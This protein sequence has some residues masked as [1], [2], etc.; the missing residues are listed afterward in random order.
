MGTPLFF[1]NHESIMNLAD[2]ARD[3]YLEPFERLPGYTFAT[4]EDTDAQAYFSVETLRIDG[5]LKSCI[6]L[7]FRG[8]ES[9]KDALI[10][11]SATRVPLNG[12]S[13]SFFGS[14]LPGGGDVLVHWGFYHQYR[15]ILPDIKE[16]LRVHSDIEHIVTTGHSLGGALATLAVVDLYD[17][18]VGHGRKFSCVSFGSPRVGNKSFANKFRRITGNRSLRFVNNDDPIPLLPS[19]LRFHHVHGVVEIETDS[20]PGYTHT[21]IPSRR[22]R[23]QRLSRVLMNTVK[24]TVVCSEGSAADHSSVK[25][26]EELAEILV[27]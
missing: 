22:Q 11:I 1:L 25:Y 3:A 24:T 7:A 8:T 5:V 17:G 21:Y 10:D 6:V 15:S 23:W 4:N 27:F 19:S 26:Y 12:K 13:T 18:K 16:Y 9:A 14:F 20:G 2:L